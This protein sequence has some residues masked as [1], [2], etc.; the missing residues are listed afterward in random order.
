MVMGVWWT[1]GLVSGNIRIDG[2]ELCQTIVI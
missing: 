1:G 2:F